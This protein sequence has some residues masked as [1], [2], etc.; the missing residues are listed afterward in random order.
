VVMVCSKTEKN[1]AAM[2]KEDIADQ[3]IQQRVELASR[4]LQQDL[5]RKALIDQRAS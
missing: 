5:K 2:T 1:L 4:Q 3:L